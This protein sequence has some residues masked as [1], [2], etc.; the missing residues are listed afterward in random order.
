LSEAHLA[1]NYCRILGR[2]LLFC[3]VINVPMMSPMGIEKNL[4]YNSFEVCGSALVKRLNILS[5][6]FSNKA[7]LR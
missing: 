3:Q 6:G 5:G 7:I 1:T 4:N 2:I